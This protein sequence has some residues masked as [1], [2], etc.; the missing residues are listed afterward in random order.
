MEISCLI[1][2]VIELINHN[3]EIT[4]VD[5]KYLKIVK[6]PMRGGGVNRDQVSKP[7]ED[8]ILPRL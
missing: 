1:L 5:I 7:F 2:D 3:N 4:Y 6:R 8:D